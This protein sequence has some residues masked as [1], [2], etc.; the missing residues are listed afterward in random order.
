MS[1]AYQQLLLEEESKK[2][3]IINTQRGLFRYN[4]LT[5]GVASAPGIFQRVMESLLSGIPGVVVYID[6]ILITGKTETDHLAA[7]DEVLK[8][9]EGAGLRLKKDKCV[10]LAPSVVYLE[11]KVDAQDIHPVAEKVKAIQ[12]AP[13]PRNVSELKSYLGLL[14]YYSRFL[15]NL[16]NTLAPLYQLLK[17]SVH[18]EWTA[19]REKAF[20]ESIKLLLTSQLLVHFDPTLKIRLACDASAYGIGAVLSHQMPDGSKKPIGFVSRILSE[21]EKKYSQIEKEGLACVFG[22][23]RFH[24]YL[25]GHHFTLQTDH[26][27]LMTLFN[28]TKEIPTQVSGRIR[29][30]ALTLA[31]YEYTPSPAERPN[32]MQ[33]QMS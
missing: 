19:Q 1:Q 4:Q 2:Y 15:P 26:K 8:R 6:D 27:P 32:N 7:L 13:Q 23:R 16:S 14:T 11:Y 20:T 3:M 22:V 17:H 24:A 29:W 21:T 25:F 33:M 30:W 18:W 12:E 31:A 9:L 5:Y 10:F 28:E